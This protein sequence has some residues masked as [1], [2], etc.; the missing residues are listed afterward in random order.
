MSLFHDHCPAYLEQ[1]YKNKITSII[2]LVFTVRDIHLKFTT[3]TQYPESGK[4]TIACNIRDAPVSMLFLSNV[5]KMYRPPTEQCT[6]NQQVAMYLHEERYN[7]FKLCYFTT[8]KPS[9]LSYSL[10]IFI[11]QPPILVQCQNL[12]FVSGF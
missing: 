1:I 5:F 12:A 7:I 3:C 4:F 8:T 9:I 6:M 11:W 10:E 2:V